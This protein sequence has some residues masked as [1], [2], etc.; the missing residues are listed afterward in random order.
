VTAIP[1]SFIGSQTVTGSQASEIAAGDW[2]VNVHTT[3]YPAG[4]IRGQLSPT[5]EPASLAL[6]GGG[7]GL[8]AFSRLRRRQRKA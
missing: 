6:L 8:V 7:L 5:P 1:T 3:V 2:Y 4:I